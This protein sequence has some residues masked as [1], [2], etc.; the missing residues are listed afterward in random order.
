MAKNTNINLLTL[1][2]YWEQIRRHKPSFFLMLVAIPL[3]AM[4][5]DT[6][7]P[8]FASMAIGALAE[9]D[10]SEVTRNLI[11]ATVVGLSGAALN[12]VGF[13]A[14]TIHEGYVF[15]DL[16][17]AT[18][19]KLIKK[20]VA[21]FVNTKVGGLTSK[22]IEFV[23][24]QISVQDL[25]IIRTLGFALSVGSGIIILLFHMWQLAIVFLVLIVSLVI[26][27]KWSLK[28]RE[29]WRKARRAIRSK[30]HGEIADSIT[31]SVIVKTFAKESYEQANIR[32]INNDYR[33][34]HLKDILFVM[35]EGSI[36]VAL[37]VV[38]QVAAIAYSLY[39]ITNGQMS[40]AIAVFALAY[41]QRIGSQLFV[42]GDILNG[43]DQALLD[44]APMT[45][46]LNTPDYIVDSPDAKPLKVSEG[47]IELRD[48][49]YSYPDQQGDVLHNINLT[50][51]SGQKVGLVGHSG[52]G[53]TTL[54][55][56]LLRFY[57]V[58]SGEIT[59]DNQNISKI[60]QESLRHAI[61]FV[62][63]EPMLFHRSLR[64]NI[65][66]G[67]DKASDDEIIAAAK[68]AYAWEFIQQLPNGL[69]TIVGERGVKLSGG[70][71][72]RIAIARAILKDAPILVLDEATSALDSESEKYI[73]G[74]LS[75]LMK[76]RTSVVIAHRLS[77]IAKLDRI[78]VMENG[79]IIE[80]GSHS[81]LLDH[82]GVYAK[83]W[84]HQSGGFI[85]E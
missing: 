9:Q 29:E 3:A 50:I 73:Q 30:L 20:D 17:S 75:K 67:H 28:K 58:S 62:P 60:T 64:E 22:F 10:T 54:V 45:E 81:A 39:L 77:T 41:V 40:I 35:T 46:V 1:K 56:L 51:E 4:L 2:L 83:L 36:R 5:I 23:R 72:Q 82:G 63:Q 26:Q 53:K 71:R 12:Y 48:V 16:G 47:T 66:Y 18:F 6:F 34:A 74:A 49:T 27:I 61:S 59:I 80:D 84:A 25:L 11:I 13:R 43:F 65:A 8:Y 76:G 15:T 31:N 21:F 78:I 14:M 69:D 19:N 70:Q 37:M 55:N 24:G 33:H 52:A 68:S 32:Q 7:L 79:Q 44:A 38:V 85:D 57:D 42:L